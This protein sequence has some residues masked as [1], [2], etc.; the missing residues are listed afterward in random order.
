MQHL[1]HADAVEDVDAEVRGPP[2]VQGGRQSLA[3]RGGQPDPRQGLRG[4]VRTQHVG[5]KRRSGEEQGGGVEPGPF[6]QNLGPRRVR[7]ETAA[8]PTDIGN[9]TEFPSP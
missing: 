5:E 2:L 8:A 3:R 6:G 1:G 4:Q 7:L 9:R